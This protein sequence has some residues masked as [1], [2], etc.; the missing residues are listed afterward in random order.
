MKVKGSVIAITGGG[1]GLGFAMAN[2]LARQGADIALIDVNEDDLSAGAKALEEYGITAKSYCCNVCDE[3]EV[4]ATFNQIVSDFGQL[5]VL[6]NNAGI[7]RD[8]MLLKVKD[9]KVT[10]KMSLEQFNSVIN[11]N[12]TGSFLCGREAA[13]KMVETNQPGVIINIASISRAG[14]IGQTNYTASKA[15]VAGMT[16][17]WAKELARY[18]IRVGAIAPGVVMTEMVGQ[19][20]LEALER[21]KSMVPLGRLGLPEEIAHSA[22]YIIENDYFTGR[23]IDIDGGLRI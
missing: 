20:K 13:A 2:S 5:D 19:M 14:N 1:R 11:V 22:T 17:T 8:G 9:G 21:M 18:G 7:L 16:V 10:Q 3:S 12:L 15:G 23:I 4:E 6:I